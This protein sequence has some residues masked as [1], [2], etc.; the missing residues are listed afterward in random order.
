MTDPRPGDPHDTAGSTGAPPVGVASTAGTPVEAWATGD[1]P[2]TRPQ[3]TYL[4]TLAREAGEEVPEPEPSKA[5]ASVLIERLQ[6]A[7][8]RIPA[9]RDH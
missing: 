7:T 1:K 6:R 9:D 4:H 8:G 5:D 2:M 3:R